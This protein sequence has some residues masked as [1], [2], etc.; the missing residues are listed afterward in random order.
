MANILS[1]SVAPDTRNV[2][3]IS[4]AIRILPKQR[5]S[6]NRAMFRLY[7]KIEY[8]TIRRNELME[9]ASNVIG[10]ATRRTIPN[11]PMGSKRHASIVAGVL[12]YSVLA[13]AFFTRLPQIERW[14]ELLPRS[15]MAIVRTVV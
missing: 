10:D 6:I 12:L 7:S 3:N 15:V 13:L 5:D 9:S 8:S 11:H 4:S 2:V 14:G 1:T